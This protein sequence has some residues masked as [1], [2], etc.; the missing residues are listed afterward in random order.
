[1]KRF[2]LIFIT[3]FHIYNLLAQPQPGKVI[4]KSYINENGKCTS[5]IQEFDL[6]NGYSFNFDSIS[7]TIVFDSSFSLIK[8]FG[9]IFDLMGSPKKEPPKP[10]LGIVFQEIQNIEN[11]SDGNS[12]EVTNVLPQSSAE[13]A[14]IKIGDRILFIDNEKVVNL[15][16]IV[17]KVQEKSVGDILKIKINR[18]GK[19]IE[20][21]AKLKARAE[22]IDNKL[23]SIGKL[24]NNSREMNF[25]E[26]LPMPQFMIQR[27][28]PRLGITVE[29]MDDEMK[30]DLKIKKGNGIIITNVIDGSNAQMAG[31]KLND[32]ILK[33]DGIPV[34]TPIEVK[35][36]VESKT[37]GSN[38]EIQLKRYGKSKKII[39]VLNEFCGKW[40][41]SLSQTKFDPSTFP[42]LNWIDE[43][44]NV[45]FIPLTIEEKIKLIEELNQSKIQQEEKEKK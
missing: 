1:M 42:D 7:Q 33:I 23:S 36:Q 4:I 8:D 40:D 44:G 29:S 20:L 41:E 9:G 31:L 43:S 15:P 45:I 14:G 22:N 39:A 25:G 6:N 11:E 13:E 2:L 37:V 12:I 17:Q 28:K 18:S 24:E 21:N 38:L 27:P 19:I 26:L 10:Y 3:F 35:N 32:V 16:Q 34:T 5:K 30:K